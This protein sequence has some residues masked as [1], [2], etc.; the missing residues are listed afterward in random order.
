[1]LEKLSQYFEDLQGYSEFKISFWGNDYT[2]SIHLNY[3]FF[4][5][6]NRLLDS[7][8]LDKTDPEY[9][10]I[11]GAMNRF[12]AEKLK[13]FYHGIEGDKPFVV[14]ILGSLDEHLYKKS[15]LLVTK[16][17]DFISVDFEYKH[18]PVSLPH[19]MK[20]IKMLRKS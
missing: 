13:Q 19:L 10:F 9:I 6:E 18:F 14:R 5:S 7:N 4:D 2:N 12:Q 11:V 20:K 16:I 1:M 15:S 3:D 8:L 17:E